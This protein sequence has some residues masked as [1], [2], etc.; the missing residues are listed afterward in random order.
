[1]K[2]RGVMGTHINVTRCECNANATRHYSWGIELAKISD[3]EVS[4][5]AG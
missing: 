2:L 4:S 1:M 5:H 3:N